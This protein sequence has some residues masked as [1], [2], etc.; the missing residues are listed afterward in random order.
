[1]DKCIACGACADKCP[2]KV[3][4]QYNENLDK[5]KAIYVQY[6]QAV[7][8]KYCI[9]KDN[10]IYLTK[11]KCGACQKICPTGAIDYEQKDTVREIKV[12]SVIMS[13]GFKAFDP[14]GY[15]TYE[16]SKY[17]N[18]VTALEFE[19]ILAAGGPWM[20]HLVRPSDEK[21]PKKIAFLQ[22][23]GSRDLNMCDNPYCS[24]VC[25]MYS[26]KEAT[27]AMEHAKEGLEVTIFY[28]DMRTFGKD[29]EKYYEKAKVKGVSFIKTRIHT[30][31][32]IGNN[33]LRINYGSEQGEIKSQEFDMVVLSH[34]LEVSKSSLELAGRLGVDLGDQRFVKTGSFTPVATS[35]PGIYVCGALNGPK[36]IPISV[37]EASAAACEAASKL[38]EGRGTLTHEK[39]IPVPVDI[40]GEAPRVGVFVCSCGINIAGVV[41]VKSVAEYAKTLPYVTFVQNNLFSC[42]QDTQNNIT[43]TIRR[44]NLN[45]V[46]VAACTPRTHEPLFQETLQSAGLNKYLF[47]LANIRNQ[48]SWVH[49][50]EPERA[51]E[52]AK[53]LVRMAVAKVTLLEPLNEVKLSVNSAALVIGGGVAGMNAALALAGQGYETH[54]VERENTLGG[55]AL[56]LRVTSQGEEIK[57]YIAGLITKVESD[58]LIRL[59]KGTVIKDVEGFVGNFKTTL[60]T[61]SGEQL[62]EHGAAI[63]TTGA[64]EYTPNEYAYGK[65]PMVMTH[66]EL[67]EALT[68]G[69]VAPKSIKTAVFIQCVGSREPERMYCSK[70]CCTH[71]VKTALL[72]KNENPN[73]RVFVLYRDMR[74]HGENELLYREARSKGVLFIRFDLDS[75]PVVSEDCNSLKVRVYDTLIQRELTIETN[76]VALASAIESRRDEKLAMMFKVPLDA[77]GWFLEAHQKLRPVDF[78]NDGVFMAGIAHYPK[79]VE[80]AITQA[81]AAVSRAVTVL[82]RK[83]M[84]LSGTVAFVDQKKCVGCG[85]CWTVCPFQAITQDAKGFASINEAL[86]KGCGNCATSCRSGAANLRGFSNQDVMA[87]IDAVM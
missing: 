57:P 67:D 82:S 46:V 64:G 24:S 26:L 79:S 2:K 69:K 85:V 54:L 62:V 78:A 70:V 34:G 73:C 44:E 28:M 33:T 61:P 71:S 25:C 36:D 37:M 76:L 40:K 21:A 41:D 43:E 15:A 17:P 42:S 32:E 58:P 74:T 55:T 11:G 31:E 60:A 1:M 38:S 77:D 30:I 18:V 81:Q 52:K 66:L 51:T 7:P 5:R 72:F 49:S 35:K 63:I 6:A 75:K 68:N 87:Q 27:I 45:R 53:D 47:E 14:T 80:E 4:N 48:N 86:C 3:E 13:T 56:K 9:D 10:C 20:G 8:L 50:D 16:Y 12:G 22:C 83:E 23:V 29:F 84:Y 19:R 39:S 65:H 59:H